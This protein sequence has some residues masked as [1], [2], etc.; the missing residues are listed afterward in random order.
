MKEQV[1]VKFSDKD[2][3]Y[4]KKFNVQD[5]EIIKDAENEQ[6]D[7][8]EQANMKELKRLEKLEKMDKK[9]EEAY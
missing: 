1:R 4:Y 8:E 3:T 5:L 6:I 7:E 9:T 2:G